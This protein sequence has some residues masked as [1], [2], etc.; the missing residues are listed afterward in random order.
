VRIKTLLIAALMVTASLRGDPANRKS[1]VVRRAPEE[2]YDLPATRVFRA[3]IFLDRAR[4][5]PGEIDGREGDDLGL[6]GHFKTGQ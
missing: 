6:G 4:I 5:S 1:S 3:Q 2:T